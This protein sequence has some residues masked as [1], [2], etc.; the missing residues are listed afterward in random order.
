MTPI[1]NLITIDKATI[2][3]LPIESYT[4]HIHI[5]DTHEAAVKAIEELQQ[6]SILG[7]DT[8]TRPSFRKGRVNKVSLIQVSTHTDCYLFRINIIGLIEPLLD[9]LTSPDIMKVGISLRDDFSVLHRV[10]RFEPHNFCDLQSIVKQ[11]GIGD[12]SLQKIYAIVYGKKLSKAQRL[13]NWEADQLSVPQQYYAA[14]DAWA[15]LRLYESFL[16]GETFYY[17]TTPNPQ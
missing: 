6:H 5:I 9:L 4:G 1:D 8:E 12:M 3:S 11:H 14:L 10:V 2:N 13:S 7:I 17:T 16:A 15:C